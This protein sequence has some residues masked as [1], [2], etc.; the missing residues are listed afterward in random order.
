MLQAKCRRRRRSR[1]FYL[2]IRNPVFWR[3]WGPKSSFQVGPRMQFLA[4]VQPKNTVSQV[5]SDLSHK[6]NK[7]CQVFAH[8]NL[9]ASSGHLML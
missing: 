8:I 7:N 4:P 6:K 1:T 3:R 5:I 2:R 9:T